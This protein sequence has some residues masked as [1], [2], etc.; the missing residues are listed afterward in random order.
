MQ[1]KV[2][3]VIK[4]H[5]PAAK[6]TPAPPVGPAL[7]QHGINIAEFCQKFNDATKDRG[8]MTVPVE[9]KIYEDGTYDFRLKQP[10]TAQLIKKM[11]G[12]EK[13]SGQ[14]NKI[15][16]GKLTKEQIRRIAQQK[17][18]DLNTDNLDAAMRIIEGTAK[19]MGIEILP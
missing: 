11:A 3:S 5:I 8:G 17:L 14:P 10:P 9:I 15:K 2:K 19:S 12:I 4:L 6:A 7:A 18:P 16:V 1:K 13:G